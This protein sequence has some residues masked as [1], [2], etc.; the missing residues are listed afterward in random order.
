MTNSS[1]KPDQNQL[2]LYVHP[3]YEA[4]KEQ[5][6]TIRCELESTL[7]QSEDSIGLKSIEWAA[8]L[9]EGEG[10]L[11]PK[12][13]DPK[14]QW[15]LGLKSTDYDVIKV[16]HSVVQVGNLC[17]PYHTPTMK[18][19]HKPYWQLN[20]YKKEAIFK[21]ICDFYPYVGERRRAKFDEFLTHH[22]GN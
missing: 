10:W 9:Y 22:Y 21:V 6:N 13:K 2:N 14:K 17:G 18:P 20:V 19:H 4:L 12:R 1:L 8:G 11:C 3:W 15:S 5:E 16:F 7:K